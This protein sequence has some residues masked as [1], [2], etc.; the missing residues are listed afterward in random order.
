MMRLIYAI[1]CYGHCSYPRSL[2]QKMA[3]D[4]YDEWHKDCDL[5]DYKG[6]RDRLTVT[7]SDYFMYY[8][9]RFK[10][11]YMTKRRRLKLNVMSIIKGAKYEGSNS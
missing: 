6:L 3:I 8:L 10:R 7:V 11:L 1:A 2:Y 9:T 5:T 4:S